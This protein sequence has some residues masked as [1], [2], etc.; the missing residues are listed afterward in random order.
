MKPAVD[1]MFP[2]G[3]GPYVDLDEVRRA[4]AGRAA[5]G[6]V[7][8]TR[9]S[10]RA[11]LPRRELNPSRAPGERAGPASQA[12][13]RWGPC[14]PASGRERS[15]GRGWGPR[16]CPCGHGRGA[17]CAALPRRTWCPLFPSGACG[18]A[19]TR[20]LREKPPAAWGLGVRGPSCAV[21]PLSPAGTGVESGLALWSP[22]SW[23]QGGFVC[24]W[25]AASWS[26]HSRAQHQCPA[27]PGVRASCS[28]PQSFAGTHPVP[29][30]QV[31]V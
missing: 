25:C 4:A 29:A 7:G 31:A 13:G 30:L 18:E 14:S 23:S 3:A 21:T 5:A 9:L 17:R 19:G 24:C 22:A 12:E 26:H 2:E 16:R 6:A 28:P 11:P 10:A 1:E 27:A 20:R 8:T 15:G